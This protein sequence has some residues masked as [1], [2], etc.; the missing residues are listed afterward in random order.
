MR[1]YAP[2]SVTTLFVPAVEEHRSRGISFTTEKGVATDLNRSASDEPTV[3]L[4]GERTAFEP[5]ERALSKLGVA[6][7]VELTADVPVGCGFGASGAATLAT[8]LAANELYSLGYDREALV[9][10]AHGAEMAAGTGQGDVFVQALGGL[11]WSGRPDGPPAR[12][13]RSEPVEYATYGDIPTA[14]VLDDAAAVQRVRNAGSELID[15]F[16]PE[17]PLEGV[18]SLGWRFARRTGLPTERVTD[19]VERVQDA[20]GAATMAMVGES[21]VG[22]GTDGVLPE[23]TRITT[24]GAR[25]LG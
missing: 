20:G 9:E 23:R 19:V 25:V 4:G 15:E 21:V 16:D 8:V 6:P 14:D 10:L 18:F 3:S 11:V 2:G 5:V 7:H 24:E 1:A 22:V 12:V 17:G 13:E